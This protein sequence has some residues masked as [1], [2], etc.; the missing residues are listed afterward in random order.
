MPQV[1]REPQQKIQIYSCLLAF[2]RAAVVTRISFLVQAQTLGSGLRFLVVFL[3]IR[4]ECRTSKHAT[5]PLSMSFPIMQRL[6]SFKKYSASL[7]ET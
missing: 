3:S 1:K 4:S 2:D 6:P 7:N 5:T